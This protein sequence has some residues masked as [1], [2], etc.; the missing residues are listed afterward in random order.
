M[1]RTP[2]TNALFG[3]VINLILVVEQA[4]YR[5]GKDRADDGNSGALGEVKWCW[6]RGVGWHEGSYRRNAEA[7]SELVLV[8]Q[9]KFGCSEVQL[10]LQ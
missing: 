9:C 6:D 2:R 1:V 3:Q 5:H 7:F 8:T 4:N 10:K